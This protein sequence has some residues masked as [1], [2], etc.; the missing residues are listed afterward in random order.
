M[1]SYQAILIS[2]W[3]FTL[4]ARLSTVAAEPDAFVLTLDG[5]SHSG[6]V[7][8]ISDGIVYQQ[9]GQQTALADVLRIE[10][11]QPSTN[12]RIK[13]LVVM[14]N[15]DR[16]SVDIIRLRD[17][18][19]VCRTFDDHDLEIPIEFVRALVLKFPGS[20]K[21]RVELLGL[22][23]VHDAT[24]DIILIENGDRITGELLD[25]DTSDAVLE[26]AN[27]QVKAPRAGIRAIAMNVDLATPIDLPDNYD[28]ILMTDGSSLSVQSLELTD[29]ALAG[30]TLFNADFKVS[31]NQ[32]T[33]IFARRPRIVPL[34]RLKPDQWTYTPFISGSRRLELNRNSFKQDLRLSGRRYP[35][36]LGMHSRS[37]VTWK[38]NG[39]YSSFVADFGIDDLA[40]GRGSAEFRVVV[41]NQVEF[42]TIVRGKS[43]RQSTG[44]INL[45]NASSLKLEVDYAIR[46][47]LF[48]IAN[49][50]EPVLI[51]K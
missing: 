45:Q 25:L 16:M 28:L 23:D 11:G 1:R 26:T 41:D 12:R 46:G 35:Q 42:E 9:S 47:D 43:P 33:A 24:D 36:G 18:S 2:V 39:K 20:T 48:D 19:V 4:L 5:I 51:L 14:T 17:D 15:G 30:K 10:T 38:L 21:Q 32:V 29:I 37:A 7:T 27:G 49:W 13:S 22:I 31:L 34:S 40:K 50:C 3:I 44:M 8:K 6:R